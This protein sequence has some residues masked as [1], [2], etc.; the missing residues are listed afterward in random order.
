MTARADNFFKVS[1]Q[2]QEDA[3]AQQREHEKKLDS[4]L[5][6]K[7]RYHLDPY[8]HYLCRSFISESDLH[9]RIKKLFNFLDGDRSGTIS[10][11]EFSEG[12][13]RCV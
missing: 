1:Q 12:I 9:S 6:Q 10:Y 3:M 8:M 2:Q 11:V 4:L 5:S 7:D 13:F